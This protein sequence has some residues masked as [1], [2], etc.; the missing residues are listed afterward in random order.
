MAVVSYIGERVRLRGYDDVFGT[1]IE[2]R[3]YHHIIQW[4]VPFQNQ[5]KTGLCP[6]DFVLTDRDAY[7]DFQ[8]RIT[9][10]LG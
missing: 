4:D 1:V 3:G 9:D 6:V 5:S 10:R 7:E 8:D 2:T